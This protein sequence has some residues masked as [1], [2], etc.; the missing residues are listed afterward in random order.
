MRCRGRSKLPRPG[1]PV[2][3][4]AQLSSRTRPDSPGRNYKG[5]QFTAAQI[6]E[7]LHGTVEGNA[8]AVVH[9]LAKIEDG[10]PGMLSFLANP[11]YTELVYSSAASV[12]I[13]NRDFK[14]SKALPE[15]LTLVRVDDPRA[16]FSHLL[17]KYEAQRYDVAGVEQASHVSPKAKVAVG[18]Y[19]GAFT[20]VA[21]GAVVEEGA[22]I[23]PN[24]Y[25]GKNARIGKGTLIHAGVKVHANCV[26]GANCVLHSGVVIGADGFGFV[27][28]EQGVQEKMPQIGNV[29]LE[30]DVEIGANTTVDRATL[31]HTII[32]KGAKLD[33]L[34]QVG[35]NVEIGA[36]TI[37]VAQTGI[38]GST[39]IGSHCL[40]GGQVGI[41]GHLHIG[42]HVKIAAQSGVGTN[43]PDDAVVQ[44]SPAY[45]IG[46]YKRSYVHFR[47]LPELKLQIDQLQKELNSLVEANGKARH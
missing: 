23:F 25:V 13:V 12:V 15:G 36:H 1:L 38:A 7:F 27:P 46:E 26:V 30:D 47:N 3:S 18:A 34:I 20:Y 17:A 32:R 19:I 6:A 42:N 37:V 33:N 8:Q 9:D 39:R 2:T 44:G 5:M 45:A 29:I 35:H 41:V 22:K 43:L 21:D 28:N 24:C 10:R 4:V 11:V 14:P 40:I 16:A 31:G